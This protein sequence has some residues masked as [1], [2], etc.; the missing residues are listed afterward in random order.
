MQLNLTTDYAIRL[1]LCLGNTKGTLSGNNIA[2]TAKIPPNYLVK[3]SSKLR[4]AGLIGSIAGSNGGYYLLKA[5]NK[6]TLLEII[7]VMEPSCKWNRCIEDDG[8]CS[9]GVVSSCPVRKYYARLQ[10]EL[11][12]KW[13]SKT[14]TEIV[15]L[16]AAEEAAGGRQEEMII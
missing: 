5:L 3:I 14:L 2:E 13:L 6:I 8:V 7:K 9:K 10:T 15:E 1:L 12:T 16:A 11:E 4:K